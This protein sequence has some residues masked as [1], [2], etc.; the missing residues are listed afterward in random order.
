MKQREL[1][2]DRKE[3]RG[4]VSSV[5]FRVGFTLIELLVVIAIIAILAAILFPVFSQVREKARATACLS[6]SRQIAL[7]VAQYS[8]DYD[9][10][11]PLYNPTYC[12]HWLGD[13]LWG[14]N[15][16]GGINNYGAL[17]PY[18][19]NHQV[20][21]CPSTRMWHMGNYLLL[22]LWA[23]GGSLPTPPVP[24]SQIDEPATT[25]VGVE[26]IKDPTPACSNSPCDGRWFGI[27]WKVS[28]NPPT[29]R[30]YFPRWGFHH[31][32]GQNL[33][34]VDGH[35]KWFKQEKAQGDILNNALLISPRKN[36]TQVLN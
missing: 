2:R 10:R 6:N 9:E 36:V 11:M 21:D 35:A 17:Q 19:K 3:V 1:M 34:F 31:Q 33:V 24:L 12:V 27:G 4:V 14:A 28:D 30:A 26:P 5:Y 32:E 23:G 8:Q 22:H 20:F 15:A 18:V 25:A 13:R 29:V 16:C 7:A